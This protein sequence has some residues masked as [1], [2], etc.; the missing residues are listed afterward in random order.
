MRAPEVVLDNPVHHRQSIAIIVRRRVGNRDDFRVVEFL[1]VRGLRRVDRGR[2]VDDVDSI[3]KLLEVVESYGQ[4]ARAGL[5]LP[6]LALEQ[7]K[8]EPLGANPVLAR[9]GEVELEIARLVG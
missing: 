9:C 7:V 8:A 5:E 6:R 2:R 1:A 4:F 3:G